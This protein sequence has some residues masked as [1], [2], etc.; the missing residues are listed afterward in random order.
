MWCRKGDYPLPKAKSFS[1]VAE[2]HVFTLCN[3]ILGGIGGAEKPKGVF[4]NIQNKYFFVFSTYTQTLSEPGRK[5]Y[6]TKT[7]NYF[8]QKNDWK[9]T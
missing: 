6:F 9:V 3:C 5:T 7:I 1:L 2:M 4:H 8:S